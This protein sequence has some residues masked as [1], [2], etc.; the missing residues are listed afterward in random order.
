MV[1]AKKGLAH[2]INLPLKLRTHPVFYV[3]MLKPYRN[4][5]H[6]DAE[7]LAARK[8]VVPQ[9]STYESRHPTSSLFEPVAVPAPANASAP[10]QRPLSE[11]NV[12]RRNYLREPN[13]RS[14]LPI[15]RSPP[16]WLEGHGNL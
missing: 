16:A 13:Q 12:S 2:T 15:H 4:S 10:H 9:A 5:S 1:M 8:T 6:V 7:A 14:L 3:D 11:A